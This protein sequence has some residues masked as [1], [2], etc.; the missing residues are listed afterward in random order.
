LSQNLEHILNFLTIHGRL[1]RICIFEP[2]SDFSTVDVLV[3]TE[4][5][6]DKD[7]LLELDGFLL[8]ALKELDALRSVVVLQLGAVYDPLVLLRTEL[9]NA[10]SA[11]AL[12]LAEEVIAFPVLVTPAVA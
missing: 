8:L 12:G 3:L 11:L 10:H 5:V 9:P 7:L 6:C 2:T 1:V 4:A